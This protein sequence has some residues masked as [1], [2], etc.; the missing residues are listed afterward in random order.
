MGGGESIIREKNDFGFIAMV[1]FKK[2]Q[3]FFCLT[4]SKN[5]GSKNE[6]R[7]AKNEGNKQKMKV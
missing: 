1:Q 5:K 3:S 7:K 2:T 6:G 4:A